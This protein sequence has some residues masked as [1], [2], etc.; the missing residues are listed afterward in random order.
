[1]QINK[2]KY[3][4][5]CCCCCCSYGSVCGGC[6]VLFSW[7]PTGAGPLTNGGQESTCDR[8]IQ[9]WLFIVNWICGI[10]QS[11][12][13]CPLRLFFQSTQ[14]H[15]GYTQK[16]IAK[17]FTGT[18]RRSKR[19][20]ELDFRRPSVVKVKTNK[21]FLQV[22]DYSKEKRIMENS[23]ILIKAGLDTGYCSGAY[24]NPKRTIEKQAEH[25]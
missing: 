2:M 22:P 6:C 21:C 12:N 9:N 14:S 23:Y 15:F 8:S 11:Q 3:V 1:M 16:W 18:N 4:S 19:S 7:D 20:L 17:Y 25:F 10:C 5:E 13:L 24:Y